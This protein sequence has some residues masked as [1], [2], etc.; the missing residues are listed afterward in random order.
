MVA[1]IAWARRGPT[2]SRSRP[3]RRGIGTGGI[4]SSSR[5][6]A[7]T[8][9]VSRPRAVPTAVNRWS[10]ASRRNSCAVAIS[11]DVCPA[12]PPPASTIETGRSDRL[13]A[14]CGSSAEPT[15]VVIRGLGRIDFLA[16]ILRAAGSSR[17]QAS[18]TPTASR[19]AISAEP[20]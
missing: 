1:L 20:P 19:L 8:T 6:A 12:V 13:I 3:G 7:G 2:S 17:A 11:G 15:T 18:S 10:G 9:V 5:P 4:S 14:G 16:S